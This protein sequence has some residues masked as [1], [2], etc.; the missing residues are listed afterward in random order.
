MGVPVVTRGGPNFAS[1]HSV[2]HLNHCGLGDWVQTSDEEFVRHCQKWA[3][4]LEELASMRQRLRGQLE[5]SPACDGAQYAKDFAQ[6]ARDI[7][8]EYLSKNH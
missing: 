2:T 1:R 7:W 4:N 5:S 3:N 8:K 6:F